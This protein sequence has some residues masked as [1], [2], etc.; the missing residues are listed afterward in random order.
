LGHSDLKAASCYKKLL[1]CISVCS[2]SRLWLDLLQ[3]S[4]YF[5]WSAIG[6]FTLDATEWN[7]GQYPIH[8]LVLSVDFQGVA[9]RKENMLYD[10]L[11]AKALKKDYTQTQIII[12]EKVFRL[13]TSTKKR[14]KKNLLSYC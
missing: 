4:L 13:E 3:W 1:R 9:D 8:I 6:H 14:V 7:F 5:I 12:G 11:I 2:P 10:K